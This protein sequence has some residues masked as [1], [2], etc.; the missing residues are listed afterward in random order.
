MAVESLMLLAALAA[1][2]AADP[3]RTPARPLI[4]RPAIQVIPALAAAAPRTLRGL[5]AEGYAIIHVEAPVG[6]YAARF[7]LLKGDTVWSCEPVVY[8]SG[9]EPDAPRVISQ[10]C[11]NLTPPD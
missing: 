1:D 6:G 4:D 2:A 8:R 10:P 7:I 11:L 5:L 3:A 9:N